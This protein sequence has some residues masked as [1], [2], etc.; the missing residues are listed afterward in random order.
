LEEHAFLGASLKSY[1]TITFYRRSQI[2][3]VFK[4]QREWLRSLNAGLKKL[5]SFLKAIKNAFYF[6]F[7]KHDSNPSTQLFLKQAMQL[8]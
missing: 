7:Y 3:P 1:A 5:N 6:I 4:S 2:K 8:R